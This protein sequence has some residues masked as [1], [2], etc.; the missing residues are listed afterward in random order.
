MKELHV[1]REPR[2]ADPWVKVICLYYY[3]CY[4]TTA[5]P[6]LPQKSIQVLYYSIYYKL[7]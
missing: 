1:A 2:V 5:T 7:L 3:S 4:V 6:E